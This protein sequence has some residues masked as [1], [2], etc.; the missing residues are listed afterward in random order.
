MPA[1]PSAAALPTLVATLSSL[2]R[3]RF[4]RFDEDIGELIL[5]GDKMNLNLFFCNPVAEK[6]IIYLNMLSA[7]MENRIHGE[8]GSI[9]VITQNG[10]SRDGGNLEIC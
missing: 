9:K 4:Y 1:S 5:R 6:V 2:V 10:R 7:S 3:H 8:I